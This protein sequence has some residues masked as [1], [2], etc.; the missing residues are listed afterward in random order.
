MEKFNHITDG[1]TDRGCVSDLKTDEFLDC[2]L[3]RDLNCDTCIGDACNRD[4]F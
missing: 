3:G 4:V 1:T 2:V